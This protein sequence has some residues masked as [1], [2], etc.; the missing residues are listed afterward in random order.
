MTKFYLSISALLLLC[1]F[2]ANAQQLMH[3][4]NFNDNTSVAALSVPTLALVPGSSVTAIAG[5]TSAIDAAGGTGQNFDVLNLNTQNSDPAGTHLRFNNPIGGAL[6]FALPTTGF[7]DLVVR[8]ATRR[9]GSGADDQIWSYTLDGST[10]LPL[11]T[12]H[13]ANGDPTLQTLDLTAIAG[14]D[15]NPNFKLKVEFAQGLGGDVGNNRFDNFTAHGT[16]IGGDT[17]APIVTIVPPAGASNIP[18]NVNPTIAFN[19]DVRLVNNDAITDANVDAIVELRI[20]DALGAAVAFDATFAGNLI[21]ITPAADLDNNQIYYVALLANTVEDLSDNAVTATAS[22]TFTTIA[23]QTTFETGDFAFVAYRMSATSTEDEIALVTFVDIPDGTNINFTDSKYTGNP[24]PQCPGG[25]VWT[26]NANSCIPAGS[27]IT[28]RT[29]ALTSN[30]GTVTGS[31]F[32]LS[33]NGDQVIVYTGTAA[34]PNY[35]TAFSSNAWIV[36]GTDCGGSLSMLPGGLSDGATSVNL[37]TAPGNVSGNSANAFYNGTQNGTSEEL[38]MA[39]LNPANWTTSPSNTAAQTW[40]VWAFP[41][42]I[43][44]TTAGHSSMQ[45]N[46]IF[47]AAVDPVSGGNLLNYTGIDNLTSVEV[48]GN[49]VTLTYS[50]QFPAGTNTLTVADIFGVSIPSMACPYVY[51]FDGTLATQNFTASNND[52]AI[53][54]NPTHGMA[55]FNRSVDVAVFDYTGKIVFKANQVKSIDATG[56]SAGLYLV[57]TSEGITRKLIVK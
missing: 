17:I 57:K 34:A 56:L 42:A 13:P 28:I 38:K 6:V 30:L 5:G 15:D 51:T 43:E 33:S 37:S 53:Y 19:E 4:W 7:E 44:I 27:V 55:N 11:M 12:L 32:G 21:T 48:N 26:A 1:S 18:V 49:E 23:D 52:F 35:I 40:P 46:F 31:G 45:I 3:Y 39:I 14:S 8:F 16:A 41:K 25:I 22:A 10:Y 9:S 36:S 24:Q 2:N 50:Q 54:P 29:N 20:G 47:D